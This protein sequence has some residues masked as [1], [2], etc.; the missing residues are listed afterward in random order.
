MK[1]IS[2]SYCETMA[3]PKMC[4]KI[5][6]CNRFFDTFYCCAVNQI[7]VDMFMLLLNIIWLRWIFRYVS[8]IHINESWV[9]VI[10]ETQVL[11]S[12]RD[13]GTKTLAVA[14]KP[15]R[16]ELYAP[17]VYTCHQHSVD[18]TPR[19]SNTIQLLLVSH[20]CMENR[21]CRSP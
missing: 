19:S 15:C 1:C 4:G 7:M 20:T 14:F 8:H 9:V 10:S 13:D 2:K 6:V 16:N 5:H 18:R 12:A 11:C 17:T 3:K 21:P